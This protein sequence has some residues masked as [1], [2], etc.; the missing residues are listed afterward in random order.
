MSDDLLETEILR[1]AVTALRRRAAR[2]AGIASNGKAVTEHG[3]VIRTGES[4]VALRLEDA[5][6]GVA[7]DLAREGA[8]A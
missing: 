3:V 7:D 5:L 1:G 2:Q 6:T 8:R 4:A